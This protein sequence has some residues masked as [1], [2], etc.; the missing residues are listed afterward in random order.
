MVS[1]TSDFWAGF[2]YDMGNAVLPLSSYIAGAIS[3][4]ILHH[5]QASKWRKRHMP[6]ITGHRA[7]IEISLIL[8]R[9]LYELPGAIRVYLTQYHNGDHFHTELEVMRKSRTHERVKP[10]IAFQSDMFQGV[11]VSTMPEETKVVLAAGPGFTAVTDMRG[12]RFAWL[13]EQGGVK[14]IARAAIRNKNNMVVG[15]VGADFDMDK[16]PANI[17]D[18]ASAAYRIGQILF[19]TK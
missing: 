13:C 17:N 4:Q 19:N 14:A 6:I 2:W 1:H 18:L 9:L 12:S 3:Q 8:D 5:I 7:D 15:F 11:L 16:S 10:G